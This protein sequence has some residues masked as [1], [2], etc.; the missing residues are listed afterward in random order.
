[1]GSNQTRLLLHTPE[2]LRALLEGQE[3][4]EQRFGLKVA[5]G[6]RE[7]LIGPEVS[8][9]F[10]ARLKSNAPADAWKDGFGV[11]HVADNV[12]IGFGGFTGPPTNDGVVEI[13]YGITP[14][15]QGRGYATET[16]QAL[17]KYAISNGRVRTIRAHTLPEQNASTRVLEK[18]GFQFIEE[19]THPVDGIVWRWEIIVDLKESS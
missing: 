9:E 16:A 4:Y 17:M 13:A 18:C 8:A 14:A 10:L 12:L 15:Y 1:M 19:I 6:V 2:H 7:F 5:D 3:I 11:L